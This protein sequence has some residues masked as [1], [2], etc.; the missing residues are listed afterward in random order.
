MQ[1]KIRVTTSKILPPIVGDKE[2]EDGI[3]PMLRPKRNTTV[4]VDDFVYYPM[5]SPTNHA[6]RNKTIK[7]LRNIF[8]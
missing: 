7:E 4:S 3:S 5:I 6:L 1:F 2:M 8:R